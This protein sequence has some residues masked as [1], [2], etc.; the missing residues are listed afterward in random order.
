MKIERLGRV[1]KSIDFTF[2]F[3]C[4][5]DDKAFIYY[6]RNSNI[7][8]MNRRFLNSLE[9]LVYLCMA[10]HGIKGYY[11]KKHTF[12]YWHR[13]WP[14]KITPPEL[15][16]VKLYNKMLLKRGEKCGDYEKSMSSI[17]TVIWKT[18][19]LEIQCFFYQLLINS[20]KFS[21]T[22]KNMTFY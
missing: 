18:W 20:Q 12:Y 7:Y 19:A 14:S 5:W 16:L 15:C 17:L 8:Y 13:L 6:F 22:K 11:T 21:S 4:C 3:F 10:W 2:L 9:S 1:L